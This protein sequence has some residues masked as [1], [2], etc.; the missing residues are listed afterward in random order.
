MKGGVKNRKVLFPRKLLSPPV[1]NQLTVTF[2]SFYSDGRGEELNK[3]AAPE[4][5]LGGAPNLDAIF[6]RH[7][8][9]RWLWLLA[10][11][12]DV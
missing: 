10:L 12:G 6:Q 3:T 7:P 9:T 1:Q 11:R 2:M 5:E 8:S 4:E